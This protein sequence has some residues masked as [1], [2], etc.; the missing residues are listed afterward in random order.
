MG[1]QIITSTKLLAFNLTF[2]ERKNKY[3]H[4]INATML[5]LNKINNQNLE[6]ANRVRKKQNKY[7]NFAD[8]TSIVYA[9][10]IS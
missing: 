4:F 8:A 6:E 2:S 5:Y 7:H 9:L 3:V 1:L 10:I